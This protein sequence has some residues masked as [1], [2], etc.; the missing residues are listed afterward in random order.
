M[1]FDLRND[2]EQPE[3]FDISPER[4]DSMS[5]SELADAME[6][7]IDGM[8]EETYDPAVIDA[9]LEAL[10]RRSPIPDGAGPRRSYTDFLRQVRSLT[11]AEAPRHTG[12]R[13]RHAVRSCL[14]AALIAVCM[15]GSLVIAQASGIDVFGAIARWS[16]QAFSFGPLPDEDGPNGPSGPSGTAAQ[17][18]KAD[19]D[20]PEEYRE[21][22]AALA[23]HNVSLRVPKVPEGFEVVDSLLFIDDLTDN[24]EF[25]VIYKK[26]ADCIG[27]N[28][29]ETKA[30]AS[31]FEKDERE[32]E[33]YEYAGVSHYIFHNLDNVTAVWLTE[34]M[35][36]SFT[37]N[38]PSVDVKELIRSVYEG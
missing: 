27:V 7:A 36:S 13:L 4:L 37:T 35:Q 11:S 17:G 30:P 28:M 8:T 20:P 19:P 3:Y 23:R 24:A 31:V 18:V 32:V 25:S 14:A 33:I 6:R 1:G 38:S 15:L 10:D 26:G 21:F 34:D 16:E 29:E 9:Y 22:Q 12:A 2:P 5:P